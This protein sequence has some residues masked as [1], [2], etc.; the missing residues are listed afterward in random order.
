MYDSFNLYRNKK[1]LSRGEKEERR[2]KERDKENQKT[3][4]NKKEILNLFYKVI[5]KLLD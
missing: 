2:E 5:L 1:S 3:N 4:S